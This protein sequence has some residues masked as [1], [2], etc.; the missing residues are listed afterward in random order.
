MEVQILQLTQVYQPASLGNYVWEDLNK[1]GIQEAGEPGK[2]SNSIV[3]ECRRNV[4]QT[5]VTTTNAGTAGYY[6]F[7]NLAP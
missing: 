1:N 6:Q 3:E 2:W 5:T 4:L 7:T